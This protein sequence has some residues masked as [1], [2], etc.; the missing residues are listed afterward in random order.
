MIYRPLSLFLGLKYT[1]A[2]S[3][4]R[5]ISFISWVSILGIALGVMVLITVLSVMNGFDREIKT[6]MLNLVP[7]VTIAPWGGGNLDNWQG[8][9]GLIQSN[10]QIESFAPFIETQ[11]M[12]STEGSPNFGMLKGIEPS[13][14]SGVS[15]IANCLIEGDLKNLTP[16]SFGIIL[17]EDLASNL[18]VGL[19]DKV[20]VIVPK[21]SLSAVGFL[22]RIKV[23]TVVGV[24]KTGYQFDGSY[25]LVNI[26]DLGKVLQIPEGSVSGV[27]LKLKDLYQSGNIVNWLGDKLPLS[28]HAFDWTYQNQNFF[29][30]LKMEKVMMFLILCLIIAVAGFNM[31]SQLVMM[32]TDK[33]SDIA[34]LRTL[35]AKSGLLIR[36]FMIQGFITGAFGTFLGVILGIILS[37]NVTNLVNLIQEIFH[38]QFLSS[39][40]YYIN[41]VPSYLRAQDV[42][43]IIGIALLISLLA[44]IYPAI[45]ASKILPAEALRYE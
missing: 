11:A 29:Q 44:T 35:G 20:S 8:L 5:F 15:P 28:D 12:I 41:F 36:I 30:A 25:G 32:V 26:Q 14:E 27:Q 43:I 2:K 18:G 42:L 17:G 21:A 33:E 23:F 38:I 24:F 1:R 16:G 10:N 40:V 6:R 39:D 22:P 37:L 34:I 13:L 31:L 4:N 19:G 3:R 9:S 7:Q 45:R